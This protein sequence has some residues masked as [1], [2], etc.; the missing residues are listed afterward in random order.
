[1]DG[2]ECR[3]PC[4]LDRSAGTQVQIA[5]PATVT[6]GDSSRY[7]FQGWNDATGAERT[8]KFGTESVTLTASYRLM[9]RL[10]TMADPADGAVCRAQPDSQDGYYDAGT[11]VALKVESRPGFK[12]RRV[13]GDLAGTYT[14][15]EL[16][17]SAPK[18]VRAVFD[19]V[20]YIAPAGVRNAAGETPVAA[21]A[22]GSVVSIYGAHLAPE[23]AIGPDSPLA[24]TLAGV[25]VRIGDRLLPLFYVSPEQINA[26]MPADMDAGESALTVKWAG[27][28]EVK[29]N[30]TVARNAPGLFQSQVDGEIYAIA[31]HEDGS[32]ITLVAPA[33]RGETVTIYGTGFGPCDRRPPEGFAVPEAPVYTQA[34]AVQVIAGEATLDPVWAGAS[35][36]RVGINALRLLIGS[37]L[38]SGSLKIAVRINGQDSNT[39]ALPVE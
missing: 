17:M 3:I 1:V 20:P 14:T 4:V 25:T 34:D 5:A 30:F 13:E 29:A 38:P 33:K 18:A 24:Q 6:A 27:Q 16:T 23:M 22:P 37:D 35:A 12:F 26:Q 7:V 9:H 31:V 28:P 32:A 19:R 21:V 36:G 2:A 11:R 15:G 8:F 39:V 10:T